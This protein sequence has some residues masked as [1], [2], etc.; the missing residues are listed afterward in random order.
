VGGD[1]EDDEEREEVNKPGAERWHGCG[2]GVARHGDA[3]GEGER[4]GVAEEGRKGVG[5][6]VARAH[7]RGGP[8]HQFL[9]G[10]LLSPLSASGFL[11]A[12]A[13]LPAFLS[14]L[15]CACTRVGGQ[16][17]V[18]HGTDAV[19]APGA[20]PL[21]SGAPK[22]GRTALGPDRAD[23]YVVPRHVPSRPPPLASTR[24]CVVQKKI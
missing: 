16:W 23:L 14:R 10:R 1:E 11:A 17:G 20:V 24:K 22:P 9:A 12:W 3:T 2:G 18:D 4:A 19:V 8:E 6:R 13:G 5:R 15:L 7:P 21:S